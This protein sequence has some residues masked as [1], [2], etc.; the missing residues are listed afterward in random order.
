MQDTE[1]QP[2]RWGDALAKTGDSDN[3]FD[4]I[5]EQMG[6]TFIRL[7]EVGIGRLPRTQS[8]VVKAEVLR[9]KKKFPETTWA[10]HLDVSTGIVC[11]KREIESI[12]PLT[13]NQE[14]IVRYIAEWVK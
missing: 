5:H 9:L 4:D 12:I 2:V 3:T 7:D 11:I 1:R 8:N 13:V 14:G 6:E 10:V